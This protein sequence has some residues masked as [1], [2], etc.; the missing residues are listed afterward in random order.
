[1]QPAAAVS[2]I[3]YPAAIAADKPV[4][5]YELNEKSGTVA[6]DSSSSP[7]NG[8]YQGGVTHDVAGPMTNGVTL[9]G[10][11]AYISNANVVTSPSSF[12]LDIW[13]RTTTR[14]GGLIIGF[15]NSITGA[16]TNYDRHIYMDS[17][18]RVCFGV[19]FNQTIHSTDVYNDGLW[20][21]ATATI[22]LAGMFLFIDGLAVG[23]SAA[24]TGVAQPSDDALGAALLR[25]L[26]RR[27]QQRRRLVR[28]RELQ[29]LRGLG[30]PGIG[31]R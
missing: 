5:W 17:S 24:T 13:F 27:L 16:S 20:H 26:A 21:E 6:Y 30:R 2:S 4:L 15:G 9:D 29:P 31:V 1:M 3:A 22:G 10:S 14:S 25:K 18:G 11:S 23:A 28:P 7:H 12:S 8:T 19:A